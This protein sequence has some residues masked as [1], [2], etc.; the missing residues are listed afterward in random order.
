MGEEIQFTDYDRMTDT[1]MYLDDQITLDFVVQLSKKSKKTG[2]RVFYQYETQ[3]YSDKY[4]NAQKLRSVKRQMNFYFVLNNKEFFNNS[5]LIKP[6]DAEMLCMII[7]SKILP[8]YFGKPEQSAFQFVGK[9]GKELA[10]K[11]YSPVSYAVS[12]TSYLTFIPIVMKYENDNT[13]KQ[14]IEIG[15]SG[16]YNIQMDIDKFMG[17]YHL[18]QADM[19]TAACTMC[20]YVKI[21]PYGINEYQMQGLGGGRPPK[22]D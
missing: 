19:Y 16:N 17:F 4:T 3:Y 18:L 7:R 11:E 21:P 15:L 5:L 22:V 6:A 20:N 13:F 12:A 10:V 14:G 8:W 1:L 9:D 2:D